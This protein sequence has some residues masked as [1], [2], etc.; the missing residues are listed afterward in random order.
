MR[1][2]KLYQSTEE[3]AREMVSHQSYSH[4]DWKTGSKTLTGQIK[5]YMLMDK[6]VKAQRA[7]ERSMLGVRLIDKKTNKRIRSKTKVK[8]A[9]EHAAKLKWSFAGHNAD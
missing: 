7:T 4:L 2:P 5:E 9:G 6:I 8:D 1:K 3:F